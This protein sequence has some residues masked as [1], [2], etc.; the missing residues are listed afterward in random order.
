MD[1]ETLKIKKRWV[2]WKD[3]DGRKEGWKDKMKR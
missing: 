1:G 2:R 3:G